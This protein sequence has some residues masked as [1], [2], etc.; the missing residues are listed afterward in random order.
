[1]NKHPNVLQATTLTVSQPH[2]R[3]LLKVDAVVKILGISRSQLYVLMRRGEIDSVSIGRS[4]RFEVAALYAYMDR[5]AKA[6]VV[7]HPALTTHSD[8]GQTTPAL[9][10]TLMERATDT[11]SFD[12]ASGALAGEQ[13]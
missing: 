2:P 7:A 5:L 10:L 8:F 3:Q 13:R 11:S 12:S 4:R 6:T 1:M 9:F